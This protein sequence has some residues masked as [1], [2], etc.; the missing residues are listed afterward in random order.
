MRQ[1]AAALGGGCRRGGVRCAERARDHPH[2]ASAT[3]VVCPT[4]GEVV[5]PGVAIA[6][7]WSPTPTRT[8]TTQC[9]SESDAPSA[10]LR[11]G[12][13]PLTA[14]TKSLWPWRSEGRLRARAPFV[15]QD[16]RSCGD[17]EPPPR[18]AE[19]R[20]LVPVQSLRL[21]DIVNLPTPTGPAPEQ[22]H[23]L[24]SRSARSASGCVRGVAAASA[25]AA[26][27]SINMAGE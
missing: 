12:S 5:C 2:L 27:A 20:R 26:R 14:A 16:A 19:S 10:E 24:L 4:T 17:I 7:V 3:T 18:R 1:W 8:Q 22:T 6:G 23:S 11:G 21:S 15:S 13:L 25:A 9:R